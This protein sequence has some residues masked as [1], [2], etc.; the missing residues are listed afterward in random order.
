MSDFFLASDVKQWKRSLLLSWPWPPKQHPS[1]VAFKINQ[2]P[3]FRIISSSA[4]PGLCAQG[5]Q[6]LIDSQISAERLRSLASEP[7]RLACVEPVIAR[8]RAAAAPSSAFDV[9]SLT[10]VYILYRMRPGPHKRNNR[11]FYGLNSPVSPANLQ[12]DIRPRITHCLY[13]KI[14]IYLHQMYYIYAY[15]HLRPLVPS[16]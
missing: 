3:F 15:V 16:I 1:S 9:I 10:F 7:G 6:T 11:T 8:T 12:Q 14:I 5:P 13:K 2:K 4:L